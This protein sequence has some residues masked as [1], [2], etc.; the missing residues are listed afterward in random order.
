MAEPEQYCVRLL[1]MVQGSEADFCGNGIQYVVHYTVC[2][3]PVYSAAPERKDY[4]CSTG[5]IGFGNSRPA[6]AEY[7]LLHA[8]ERKILDLI[9]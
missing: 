3:I 9:S 7:P 1:F 5:R 2:D 8:S 4:R 6:A